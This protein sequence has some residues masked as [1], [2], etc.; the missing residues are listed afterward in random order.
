MDNSAIIKVLGTAQ[1]AGI[2]QLNCSCDHCRA[3]R[4]DN[5]LRQ[6]P[7]SIAV[8]DKN[9]KKT[10]ILDAAPAFSEQLDNL[11]QLLEE[12]NFSA[13]HLSGILLTHAHLGHYTGLMYLGKEALNIFE[14]P[15]YLSQKMY[16][17]LKNNAPWSDLFKNNNLKAVVFEFEKVYQLSKHISFKAVEVEHR[18]E[19]ADTAAFIVTAGSKS[20][21]YLPDF[22][23]WSSFEQQFRKIIKEIDYALID[24]TFFDKEEL[25]EIRGRELAQVP[26]PPVK[27]T[28]EL[29]SDL[30]KSEKNKIYF[31]HFNHTN[32]ILDQDAKKAELVKINGFNILKEGKV[33]D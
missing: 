24:G 20:F 10:F 12:E 26:H 19:H 4:K 29:L 5:S 28:M 25:G 8:V 17:F 13:E 33:L 9:E 16:D 14:L 1:D 15:I 23:S 30:D 6:L 32:R 31:T 27:E 2:P 7:S 3:A 18:N 22:D 21:L 11:N